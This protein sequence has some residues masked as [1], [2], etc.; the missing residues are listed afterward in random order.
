MFS[1]LNIGAKAII[2]IVLVVLVCMGVMSY[3]IL[4][5][6]TTEQQ[7]SA[8][9]LLNSVSRDI[10]GRVSGYFNEM[11]A[12]IASSQADIQ[13]NI[14]NPSDFNQRS[15]I[16]S[17]TAMLDSSNLALAAFVYLKEGAYRGDAILDSRNRLPNGDFFLLISDSDTTKAGGIEIL[18]ADEK[19]LA[20]ITSLQDVMSTGSVS[21]GDPAYINI[22]G[23]Q[24]L[25]SGISFP[26]KNQQGRVIGVVGMLID[27]ELMKKFILDPELSVFK[28]DYRVLISHNLKMAVHPN[29]ETLTKGLLETNNHELTRKIAEHIKNK[30]DGTY[31][32]ESLQGFKAKMA[33]STFE[34]GHNTGVY[35]TSGVLAPIDSVNAV[36]NDIQMTII[37][38]IVVSLIV[39]IVFISLY[40]RRNISLRLNNVLTHLQDFFKYLNY[41]TNR[42]PPDLKPTADDELGK[43]ATEINKSIRLTQTGLDKDAAAVKQSVDVVKKIEGGDLTA[44]ITEVPYNPKLEE[45][46]KV[47]NQMLQTMQD[48]IGSN[49]NEIERVFNSYTRLDFTTNVE[50]AQGRVELVTN[51]LGDEI[52]KML[53]TSASFASELSS[54]LDNLSELMQKL[55][56]GSNMQANSLEQSAAAIEEITSSMHNVSDRTTQVIQQTDEI[57]SVITIIKDIADQTNLLALNAAIEAARAGE[58]GRGFAVVADE[59]RQLAE[60]TSKSLTEIESSSNLLVQSINDMAAS[61]KEQTEG[62]SQINEAINQLESVTRENVGIANNTNDVTKTVNEMANDLMEDVNKKKF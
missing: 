36:I 9:D 42:C 29:S 58:H 43:M 24:I 32:Y 31:D 1:K 57:K 12:T 4:S 53:N 49:V 25:E 34:V 41:E 27:L 21:A 15:L 44:R 26:I 55:T 28:G 7:K 39:I 51:T 6:V 18:Q 13:R 22:G 60:K 47:L 56:D 50:N 35:W 48:K 10:E 62:I 37:I 38:S 19:L 16:S 45:L 5:K 11:Y 14:N 8:I 33:I 59:V 20:E 30:Q 2:S 61:I 40:M 17:A 23:S 54:K 3:F 52:R 46:R